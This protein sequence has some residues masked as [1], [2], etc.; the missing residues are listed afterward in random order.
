MQNL[1]L[2]LFK[3]VHFQKKG[4]RFEEQISQNTILKNDILISVKD[5]MCL[6]NFFDR[7][8]KYCLSSEMEVLEVEKSMKILDFSGFC[9]KFPIHVNYN[10]KSGK[11]CDFQLRGPLSPSSDNIFHQNKILSTKV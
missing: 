1:H 2:D 6:V 9:I 11:Y 4:I 10:G 3:F 8:L 7:I 5:H